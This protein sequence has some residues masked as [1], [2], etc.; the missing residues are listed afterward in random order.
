MQHYILVTICSRIIVFTNLQDVI[1]KQQKYKLHFHQF[2]LLSIYKVET[3]N[4]RVVG[5][6]VHSEAFS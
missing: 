4:V 1:K 3:T 5:D 2:Q 6:T